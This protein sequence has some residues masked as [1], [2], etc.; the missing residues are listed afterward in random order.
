MM[1]WNRARI[2]FGIFRKK[3]LLGKSMKILYKKYPIIMYLL[4]LRQQQ[5]KK[6]KNG[7]LKLPS[8]KFRANKIE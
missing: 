7:W 1:T 3:S 2:K 8:N 6:K 5:K 4:Q